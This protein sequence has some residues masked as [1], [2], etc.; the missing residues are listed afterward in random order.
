MLQ[1]FLF[2]F[3]TFI[4]PQLLASVSSSQRRKPNIGPKIKDKEVFS[5]V[6]NSI[7]SR[8]EMH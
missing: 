3:L 1:S 8:P 2:L 4:S 6:D 5:E 7:I